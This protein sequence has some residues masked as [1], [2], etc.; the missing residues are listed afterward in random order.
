MPENFSRDAHRTP[1]VERLLCRLPVH[2]GTAVGFGGGG[3]SSGNR[4][5]SMLSVS[6]EGNTLF[7]LL[8]SQ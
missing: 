6:L 4:Y 8:I 7:V 5:I 3:S 2:T 1:E